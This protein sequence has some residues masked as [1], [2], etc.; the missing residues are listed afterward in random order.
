[1]AAPASDS[2]QTS[3]VALDS[4]SDTTPADAVPFTPS[5]DLLQ[6]A[7]ILVLDDDEL[8]LELESRILRSLGYR[9]VLTA[10]SAEEALAQLD[11]E[12]VDIIISDLKM[13]EMDGIAFLR[14]LV[15]SSFRGSVI[16]VSSAGPRVLHTVRKIIDEGPLTV[17]G[18]LAKP[19][20]RAALQALLDRWEPT[21]QFPT[22]GGSYEFFSPA[23]L[24][25]ANRECQ[26]RLHYQPQVSLAT[27]ELVGFEA[28]V[29]WQHPDFGLVYP[30]RFI[31]LAEECGAIDPLTVWV[32]REAL[33]HHAAWKSRGFDAQIAV[34]VSMESLKSIDFDRRFAELVRESGSIPEDVILEVTESRVIGSA[35]TPL[36]N[37][38][39]LRME[40]F[41]LSIDDYGTGQSSLAQLRD[42]PFTELKL[43]RSFVHGAHDDPILMPILEHTLSMAR[44]LDMSTVAEGVEFESDWKLL[45][46]LGCA[47]AQGYFIGRP[48]EAKYLEAWWQTWQRRLPQLINP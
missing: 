11:S 1:M 48:M 34:N 21:L 14:T 20:S 10:G 23:D 3:L 16:L 33:A 8:V 2:A 41:E 37:L 24:H 22:L 44:E 47:R 25:R 13:P 5:R 46:A 17:L 12:P 7:S 27:G 38:A 15:D 9:R 6:Q 26:W 39:R 42:L 18:I 45:R 40:H 4:D 29:R 30:D 35:Q 32:A 31:G 36:E 19:A 43:D 28:L